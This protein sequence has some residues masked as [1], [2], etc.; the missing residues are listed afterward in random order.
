MKSRI[1]GRGSFAGDLRILLGERSGDNDRNTKISRSKPDAN[2][3]L[4]KRWAESSLSLGRFNSSVALATA[5]MN[6]RCDVYQA[7]VLEASI[8]V[9]LNHSRNNSWL[10]ILHRPS[11]HLAREVSQPDPHQS[12]IKAR[13]CCWGD[14]T[15][16]SSRDIRRTALANRSC[17]SWADEDSL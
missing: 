15:P 8:P 5:L 2:I 3:S 7:E 12:L 14:R 17:I 13:L 4:W 11:Y 6:L 16:K 9:K 10:R 1:I